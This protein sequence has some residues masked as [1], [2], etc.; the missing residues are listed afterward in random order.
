MDEGGMVRRIGHSQIHSS[1]Y[2]VLIFLSLSLSRVPIMYSF[3]LCLVCVSVR[4][5]VCELGTHTHIHRSCIDTL[6]L[7]W[8]N[9][10]TNTY[11]RAC[12]CCASHAIALRAR[13]NGTARHACSE[14]GRTS[15][16]YIV[17]ATLD[18]CCDHTN[19]SF[20]HLCAYIRARMRYR[21]MWCIQRP[22]AQVCRATWTQF[23]FAMSVIL[24]L[25]SWLW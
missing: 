7:H 5:C 24:T 16:L 6:M 23:R 4:V 21:V 9:V 8:V 13:V 10:L 20:T 18:D 11:L 17:S 19:H 1:L 15:S 22:I 3:S 14:H 12:W 2:H 25:S